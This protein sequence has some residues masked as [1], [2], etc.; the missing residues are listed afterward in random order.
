M[1]L[2]QLC[3][4]PVVVSDAANTDW[5]LTQGA[6]I[7]PA[8]VDDFAE[9]TMS[10]AL[11]LEGALIAV[12]AHV[13]EYGTLAPTAAGTSVAEYENESVNQ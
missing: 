11:P 6:D 3:C 2:L 10:P 5:A 13:A 9:G 1:H 4:G 8:D 7:A 12:G